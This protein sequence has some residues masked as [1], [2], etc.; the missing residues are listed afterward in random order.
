[1][2]IADPLPVSD[3]IESPFTFVAI[4]LATTLCPNIRKYG[5]TVSDDCGTVQL[6]A[7]TIKLSDPRQLMVSSE[8]EIPSECLIKME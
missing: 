7:A 5:A 8:T 4:I 2:I 6:A 1:M 3:S